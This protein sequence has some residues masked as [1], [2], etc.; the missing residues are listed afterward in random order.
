MRELIYHDIL[1]IKAHAE[2]E[3]P[4][5]C[6]GVLAEER[7]IRCTNVAQ[8]RAMRVEIA[9]GEL[10]QIARRNKIVGFY[11]SHINGPA[12]PSSVDTARWIPGVTYVIASVYTKLGGRVAEIAAFEMSNGKLV[13]TWAWIA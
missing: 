6:V 4:F 10:Q 9:P 1:E 7:V 12:L 2:N 13:K 3:C 8:D 11:H 5:E